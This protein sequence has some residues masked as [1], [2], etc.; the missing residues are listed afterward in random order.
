MYTYSSSDYSFPAETNKNKTKRKNLSNPKIFTK[1][2]PKKKSLELKGEKIK[3]E[4]NYNLFQSSNGKAETIIKEYMNESEKP[5]F[6]IIR[7]YPRTGSYEKRQKFVI[8]KNNNFRNFEDDE[9]F[10]K[11]EDYGYQYYKVCRKFT[12]HSQNF[13]EYQGFY[14]NGNNRENDN[15][16]KNK[17]YKNCKEYN[18][19][20]GN[21]DNEYYKTYDDND[22]HQNYKYIKTVTKYNNDGNYGKLRDNNNYGKNYEYYEEI[23][24]SE[25]PRN[26]EDYEYDKDLEEYKEF[27]EWKK[28]KEAKGSGKY[29]NYEY[30]KE[31]K[32]YE[33][34][35][36]IGNYED[37]QKFRKFKD[38]QKTGNFE[39][40]KEFKSYGEK[41]NYDYDDI[42]INK[43]INNNDNY[44]D[45]EKCNNYEYY[46]EYQENYED[47]GKIKKLKKSKHSRNNQSYEIQKFNTY[48]NNKNYEDSGNSNG[49]YKNFKIKRQLLKKPN[50]VNINQPKII[51]RTNDIDNLEINQEIK[52]E[53]EDNFQEVQKI[54]S[55]V[56]NFQYKETKN[57]KDP[58]LKVLV[59]HKRMSSPTKQVK[60]IVNTGRNLNHNKSTRTYLQNK[61]INEENDGKSQNKNKKELTL[62]KSCRYIQPS[63]NK[64]VL[65]DPQKS[66]DY[67][68]NNS[69][70]FEET[71]ENYETKKNNNNRNGYGVKK[72]GNLIKTKKIKKIII[73]YGEKILEDKA[74][75]TTEVYPEDKIHKKKYFYKKNIYERKNK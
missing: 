49:Y 53:E 11:D 25:H 31:Y 26:K 59:V 60:Y 55:I 74:Y 19:Y 36:D 24:K 75:Q 46:K 29:K 42:E 64:E 54:E 28:L 45:F 22:N 44:K 7:N 63:R 2:E 37:F 73:P 20:G 65:I 1:I 52:E 70:I 62:N 33:D 39:N 9:N 34:Q 71:I 13:G 8:S 17:N 23:K 41:G 10:G 56:D 27:L 5:P 3:E 6:K 57:L 47:N 51:K 69:E 43:N 40:Y 18:R 68:H 61:K 12:G 67:I 4:K 48:Q 35:G 30:Y 72:G 58:K 32:K 15:F 66:C 14:D 21:E 38:S 50:N 16:G